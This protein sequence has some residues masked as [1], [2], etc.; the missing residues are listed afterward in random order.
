MLFRKLR[1]LINLQGYRQLYGYTK[2]YRG[3]IGLKT[4]INILLALLEVLLAVLTKSLIDAA[5]AGNT[6]LAWVQG[7]KVAALFL[8]TLLLNNGLTYMATKTYTRMIHDLQLRTLKDYYGKQWTDIMHLKTGDML[9]RVGG[10][11]TNVV[12]IWINSIPAVL[13]LTVQLMAAF[14]VLLS[15]DPLYASIALLISPVAILLSWLVGTRLR[16]LTF[17]LQNTEGALKSYINESLRNLTVIKAF[18]YTEDNLG[19]VAMLQKR[20]YH[21]IMKRALVG[22]TANSLMSV[23]YRLGYFGA[24]AF[25]T[26]RLITQ[27]ISF[28]T[29]TA[30]IQLTAQIQDPMAALS[31]TL[32]QIVASLASVERLTAITAAKAEHHLPIKGDAMPASLHLK[33]IVYGYTPDKPLFNALNLTIKK[34]EKIAIIGS[35]GEGKTTLTRLLLSLIVPSGGAI[36]F[37]MNDGEQ[38]AF[39]AASRHYFSYVPQNNSLFSGTIRENMQLAHKTAEDKAIHKALKAACAYDFVMALEGGL[40]A[41]IGEDA[42]GLSEGQAQ[43]LSIARALLRNAPFLLFDEATSA[44][45]GAT[46]TQ[47]VTNLKAYYP[48]TALIAVTHKDA[49]YRICD[50]VLTL[51]DG[52][53]VQASP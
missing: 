44:L 16:S 21:L 14:A 49:L 46:E 43:R 52:V 4:F 47:L 48:D 2:G 19:E 3:L 53:L 32:P 13:A 7:A 29:F 30:F 22:I 6:D 45:D 27:G 24:I 1:K 33:D 9:T 20:K 15:Y 28:G 50:R 39:S 51:K 35:S 42:L 38:A 12:D 17:A 25:G 26:F 5:V 34:G 11:V 41:V 23:G 37:Q 40:D 36:F 31:G 18:L 10:D 8:L